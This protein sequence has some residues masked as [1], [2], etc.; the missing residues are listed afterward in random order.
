M[1]FFKNRTTTTASQ[2]AHGI[3]EL[4]NL[5]R[6]RAKVVYFLGIPKRNENRVRSKQ[7]N[8]FLKAVSKTSELLSSIKEEILYKSYNQEL[9]KR[10]N[11]DFFERKRDHSNW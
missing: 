4:A 7:V 2:M 1:I 9:N 8:D 11:D 3:I 6:H 10:G 5:L